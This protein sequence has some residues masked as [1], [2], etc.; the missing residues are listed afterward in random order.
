[1]NRAIGAIALLAALAPIVNAADPLVLAESKQCFSCHSLDK[2]R[3]AP[4]FELLS[5]NYR[6]VPNADRML[7]RKIQLGGVGHWGAEP[8][9]GGGPRPE[10]SEA[11]ARELAAWILTLK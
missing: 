9:P 1:M 8:M 5:R 4:S 11:E 7:E 3:Q 6:R 2:E 10:V